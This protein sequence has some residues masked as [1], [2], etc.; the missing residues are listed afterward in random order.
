MDTVRCADWT[1]KQPAPQVAPTNKTCVL[2]TK[3]NCK[4]SEDDR[5]IWSI[6]GCE[7]GFTPTTQS[8]GIPDTGT[9]LLAQAYVLISRYRN[10]TPLG[11]QPHM[12]AHL[13]D[14]WL[15]RAR[16]LAEVEKVKQHKGEV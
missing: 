12:I 9:E 11:N 14:E 7:N 8:S 3:V 4:L 15:N 10:E 1:L 16:V 2:C 13:A 6:Y 5:R